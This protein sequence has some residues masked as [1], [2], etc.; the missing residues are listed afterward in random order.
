MATERD[1][2]RRRRWADVVVIVASVYMF[3]AAFWPIELVSGGGAWEV[4]NPVALAGTYAAAGILGLGGL[5]M[6]AKSTVIGR[7]LVGIGGLVA[8]YGLTTLEHLT[9]FALVS[10]GGAGLAM[11]LAASFVGEMPTPEQ[12]GKPR[13]G[14]GT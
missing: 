2:L 8:L 7:V 13:R 3:G 6:T 11:L 5:F 1:R 12:E 10:F 9:T 4:A 14:L